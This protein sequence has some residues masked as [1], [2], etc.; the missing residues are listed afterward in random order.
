MLES[1]VPL[2]Q[3]GSMELMALRSRPLSTVLVCILFL[4][5]EVPGEGYVAGCAANNSVSQYRAGVDQYRSPK[6]VPW[7]SLHLEDKSH[8][9]MPKHALRGVTCHGV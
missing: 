5:C 7:V 3:E 9:C 1:F 8:A 2:I 4:T 6:P